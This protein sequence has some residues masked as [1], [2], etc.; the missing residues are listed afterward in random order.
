MLEISSIAVALGYTNVN[1]T[2][3]NR[4]IE[5]ARVRKL[6]GVE[7]SM[8]ADAKHHSRMEVDAIVG[9]AVKIAENKGVKVPL[10]RAVYALVKALDDSFGR[11][12]EKA[13]E[14]EG[15]MQ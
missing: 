3:V 14:W 4:Q 10:L 12:R 1:E 8:L 6:P 11:E 9:N 5:R 15:S 13:I 2:E 7:P